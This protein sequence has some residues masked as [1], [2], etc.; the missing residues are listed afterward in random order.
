M[1]SS[2]K[3]ILIVEDDTGNRELLKELLLFQ[4]YQALEAESGKQAMACLKAEAID[5]ILMDISLPDTNGLT[6]MKKIRTE[7]KYADLPIIALTA[8]VRQADAEAAIAA[9]ATSH[10]SKPVKIQELLSE[11]N[12]NL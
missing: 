2:Q 5:L 12:K 9:G 3:L 6:L 4:G 1:S 8:Y 10:I 11:I 7:K